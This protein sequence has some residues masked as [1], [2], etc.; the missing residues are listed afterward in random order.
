MANPA[1]D[2]QYLR[3]T[4]HSGTDKNDIPNAKGRISPCENSFTDDDTSSVWDSD[5]SDLTNTDSAYDFQLNEIRDFNRSEDLNS[6]LT[7]TSSIS[8]YLN[9]ASSNDSEMNN[10]ESDN[11]SIIV[12]NPLFDDTYDADYQSEDEADMSH[13]EDEIQKYNFS[14]EE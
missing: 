12:T 9:T 6:Y 14:I 11:S 3:E 7:S 2:E 4:L 13:S 10:S 1:Q 8:E 5:D